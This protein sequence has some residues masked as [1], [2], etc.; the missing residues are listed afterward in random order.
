[1]LPK[2][3]GSADHGLIDARPGPQIGAHKGLVVESGAEQ[4]REQVVDGAEVE[5][6]RWPA[7]LARSAQSI[8]KLDLG[9]AQVRGHSAGTTLDANQRVRLLGACAEEPARPVILERSPDEMQAIEEA[10]ATERVA[11]ALG[12]HALRIGAEV[13]EVRQFLITQCARI[14][15]PRNMR[16][17]AVAEL[18]FRARHAAIGTIDQQ[19]AADQCAKRVRSALPSPQPSPRGRGGAAA[20]T[21]PSLRRKRTRCRAGDPFS[22]W[23]K[24]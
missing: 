22:P 3:R 1:G 4:R 16:F 11:P 10:P 8:M 13:E 12:E 18:D 7:I 5:C 21:P 2:S 15:S 6:E 17:T 14:G 23:E 24:V 19:H 9:R 20:P